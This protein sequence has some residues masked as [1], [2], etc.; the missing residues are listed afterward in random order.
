MRK[1]RPPE[2]LA[3]SA[4][5]RHACET[6]AGDHSEEAGAFTTMSSEHPRRQVRLVLR[7][8]QVYNVALNRRVDDLEHTYLRRE[9][10]GTLQY[11]PP[12]TCLSVATY[13]RLRPPCEQHAELICIVHPVTVNSESFV[14]TLRLPL[15][16]LN[17]MNWLVSPCIVIPLS[18]GASPSIDGWSEDRHFSACG[19]RPISG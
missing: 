16:P 12:Q 10:L 3:L 9:N 15:I 19:R 5:E 6:R 4:H 11:A 2:T 18:W 8:P 13:G 17:S 1:L 7:S 14:T